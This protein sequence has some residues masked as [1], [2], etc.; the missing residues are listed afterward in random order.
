M[1]ISALHDFRVQVWGHFDQK[2]CLGEAIG[3]RLRLDN[4][5][6]GIIRNDKISDKKVADPTERVRI[7]QTIHARIEDV[8]TEHF[9]VQLTSKSSDLIDKERTHKPALDPYYDVERD[10]HDR[11]K[12]V[13]K[14]EQIAKQSE[15]ERPV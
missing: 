7:G 10:E 4:G 2:S 5:V 3:V 1:A 6:M 11:Q 13:D 8:N 14:R 12:E 15:S 9:V